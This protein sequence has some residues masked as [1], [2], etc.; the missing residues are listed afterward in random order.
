M[1]KRVLNSRH[2]LIVRWGLPPMA[3][4]LLLAG[5]L[6]V[7][8]GRSARSPRAAAE[9]VSR[10]LR[11]EQ[12]ASAGKLRFEEVGREAGIDFRHFPA[13]R[14]S[15][16]PE[17]MGSGAAWGDY[18]DDGDPDL[19]LVNFASSI[20]ASGA[21]TGKRGRCALYRNNGDGTFT[22]VTERA[23]VGVAI[24]GMGAA[25]G[26]YDSDGDVD[27]Y[28]TAY[29]RNRLFENRGGTFSEVTRAA[30]VGDTRFSTGAAWGDYDGDGHIDL[31]VCNYVDF[32]YN[33]EDRQKTTS[34][35]G[36]E[37]PSTLNPTAYSPLPNALYHNNGDG[38]FTEVASEAGVANP[39]GRSLTATWADL[40][41]DGDS[42][43]YVGNDISENGVYRNEGDGSFTDI[44]A[45][46]LAADYRAA[47]GL[48]V[49]DP[50]RDRDLDLFVTHWVAQQ[51]AYFQNMLSARSQ[52]AR[53]APRLVFMDSAEMLGLGHTSLDR[54]GWSTSFADLDND[55]R[56]DLWVVNGH[57]LQQA[58]APSRLQPQR[59]QIF[60]HISD[61][62]YTDVATEAC[63]ALREPLVGR[64][65]A[66]ADYNRDG[67][68]DLVVMAHGG[69]PRLLKNTTESGRHWLSVRLRQE[70]KNTRALGAR[71]R[72]RAGGKTRMA[73]VG[74]Q[75]P[76]LSQNQQSLHFGLGS[77]D[78]VGRV[79]IRWP[80]GSTEVHRGLKAD[81]HLTYTHEDPSG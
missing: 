48:A 41:N 69:R 6:L 1:L 68:M 14:R 17:D 76:Y 81:Q 15:V 64:G 27:L 24:H 22:D 75:G 66:Q 43:L 58:D 34:Q 8:G 3:G 23:G 67:R 31:Y 52:N 37:V 40:D 50:D 36:A 53:G 29:G 39:R 28:V 16:L 51:N 5:A 2:A 44:G 79:R 38:T 60:R 18:D 47:M 9:G 78:T 46:S 55:G 62:V 72:V 80:D 45:E 20:L 59:V 42:D 74:A 12:P 33:P 71:V 21:S 25:W 65:G 7:F 57:T 61:T 70:G 19:F 35:Y 10:V 26:D 11:T 13:E 32:A 56:T 77:A 30:G 54:V 73:E 63:A 4:V 49:A